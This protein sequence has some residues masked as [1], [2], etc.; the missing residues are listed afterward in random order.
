MQEKQETCCWLLFTQ[1]QLKCCMSGIRHAETAI[2]SAAQV[3]TAAHADGHGKKGPQTVG[4]GSHELVKIKDSKHCH[5]LTPLASFCL[6]ASF[7]C[8]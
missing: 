5:R 6:N 2:L 8:F 3:K 7:T 4:S 1:T